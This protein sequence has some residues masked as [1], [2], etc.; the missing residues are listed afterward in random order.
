MYRVRQV[1][2]TLKLLK[3]LKQVKFVKEI[4]KVYYHRT[5]DRR[6]FIYELDEYSKNDI[7]SFIKKG[8][9]FIKPSN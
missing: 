3:E 4:K 2:E 1:K 9:I 8:L 7:D 5:N 6:F